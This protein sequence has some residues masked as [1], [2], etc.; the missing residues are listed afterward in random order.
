MSLANKS[1]F[2]SLHQRVWTAAKR[3]Q[4]LAGMVEE[5]TKAQQNTFR[6]MKQLVPSHFLAPINRIA[7]LGRAQHERLTL[8][9]LVKGQQLLATKA[10][11][12]YAI[13]QGD[14][15]E[16]FWKEVDRFAEIYPKIIEMAPSRLGSAFKASDYP[17]PKNIR[18]HF[19]Y[20]LRFSP[21]P[22]GDNWFMD[23][24]EG[25]VLDDLRNEVENEKNEMFR[26]ATH[27]LMVR[28]KEILEK[29]AKQAAEYQK[30]NG[31]LLSD[32]TINA[33]KDMAYLVNTM[34]ITEDP[35]LTVI[36]KEMIQEFSDL[37]AKELRGNEEARTK[38]AD[39]TKRILGRME[40]S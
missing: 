22:Q 33:V 17:D 31:N 15:K 2:V 27:E 19:D 20:K 14:L 30:T 21:V 8:P 29:L 13:I 26:A 9:G 38:I 10:F 24:I 36:G 34:N 37:D 35:K 32:A 1:M 16:E 3:D 25:A 11:E 18:A 39:I 6:V 40:V 23:G 4:S 12:E 7:L 28:T 5:E